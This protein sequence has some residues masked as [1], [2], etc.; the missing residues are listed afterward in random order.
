MLPMAQRRETGKKRVAAMRN[1]FRDDRNVL[2]LT[3]VMIVQLCG[4]T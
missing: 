3:I 1:F 4:Y 2:K